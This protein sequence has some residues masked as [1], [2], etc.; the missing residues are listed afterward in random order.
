MTGKHRHA[1]ARGAAGPMTVRGAE[2]L[3]TASQQID[4]LIDLLSQQPEA[5]LSLPC[6]GR[7]NMGDGTIA[8]RRPSGARR[9]IHGTSG[10]SA[11]GLGPMGPM[12][13]P[14]AHSAALTPRCA[15]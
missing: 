12:T 9:R 15:T 2:L 11:A 3:R 10:R 8:E 4:T 14:P 13:P 6:P 7:E 1:V 5:A